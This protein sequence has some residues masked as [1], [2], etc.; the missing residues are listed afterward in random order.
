MN[1]NA[2]LMQKKFARVVALY[3]KQS[4]ISAE[5]ALNRFYKSLLY[6]LLCEGISDLHCMSD[7]YLA[8]E[9]SKE[10]SQSEWYKVNFVSWTSNCVQLYFYSPIGRMLSVIGMKCLDSSGHEI[11]FPYV[12]A[13][14]VYC[15]SSKVVAFDIPKGG[16]ALCFDVINDKEKERHQFKVS[17]DGSITAHRVVYFE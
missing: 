5:T 15:E 17:F 11:N 9:L 1:A 8:E 2:V 10:W 7:S 14:A 12:G 3:A 6:T 4:G 13:R 16:A